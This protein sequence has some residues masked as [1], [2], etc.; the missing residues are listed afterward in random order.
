MKRSNIYQRV[1]RIEEILLNQQAKALEPTLDTSELDRLLTELRAER[2]QHSYMEDAN[3]LHV[4][5]A[6]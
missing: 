4:K 6:D 1:A 2:A 3:L 5:S